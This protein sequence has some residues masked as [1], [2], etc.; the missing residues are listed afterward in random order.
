MDPITLILKAL[1]Q[2]ILGI[3]YFFQRLESQDSFQH[4]KHFMIYAAKSMAISYT[5]KNKV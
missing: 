5:R 2:M 3:Q 1:K 4:P